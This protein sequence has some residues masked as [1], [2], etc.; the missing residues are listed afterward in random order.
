MTT[1]EIVV[2]AIFC[3]LFLGPIFILL[4]GAV[5]GG[6]KKFVGIEDDEKE[7]KEGTSTLNIVFFI[8]AAI[9]VFFAMKT[10]ANM[11]S[12]YEYEPR[13]SEVIN[14]PSFIDINSVITKL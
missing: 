9:I 11:D 4:T 1:F 14:A 7:K 2:A 3:L 5:A 12:D 6:L 13:H 8:I 10:C